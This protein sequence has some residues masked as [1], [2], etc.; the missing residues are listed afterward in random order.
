MKLKFIVS[1]VLL[2]MLSL[3]AHAGDAAKDLKE[4]SIT[5]PMIRSEGGLYVAAYG[6][7]NFSTSYGNKR[8]VLS[9]NGANVDIGPG[10]VHSDVGGVGGIKVGYNFDSF[11]ICQGFHLQPAVEG[12]AF[13]IGADSTSQINPSIA[14]AT[15]KISYNSADFFANGLIRFKIDGSPVVPYIG[16]GVG[17]QYITI[18]GE[19]NFDGTPFKV[20]G[21]TGDDVDFA[22]QVLGGVDYQVFPHWTLF[23]EYKFVDAIGT[24]T[25]APWAGFFGPGVTYRFKPD[26]IAQQLATAGLKYNF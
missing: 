2:A 26:Q 4:F 6:G 11:D 20:T 7:A 1:T 23:T 9:Q 21:L 19:Q 25:S 8:E 22:A 16:L 12:E 13:Y 3:S 5:P 10:H 14:P 24:N 15:E 18:H 17:L